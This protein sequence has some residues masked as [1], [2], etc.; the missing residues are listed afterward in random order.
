M[1][2][3]EFAI[4]TKVCPFVFSLRGKIK[5]TQLEEN[6]TVKWIGGELKHDNQYDLLWNS[7]PRLTPHIPNYKP[8]SDVL[9][10]PTALQK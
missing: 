5:F 2:T 8:V 3:L 7:P 10:F 1:N 6:C 9:M 4:M